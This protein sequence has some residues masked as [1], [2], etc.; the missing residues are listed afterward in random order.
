[1]ANI[2]SLNP[3]ELKSWLEKGEALLVDVRE[4][5]EHRSQF[6]DQALNLPLSEMSLDHPSF[7]QAKN[8]KLVFHCKTGQRS[9]LACEKLL[10][11]D[12]KLEIW[13]LTGGIDAWLKNK[14][15]TKSSGKQIM[16][17][18]RQVQLTISLMNL[19]GLG[20]Y[21]FDF[22]YGLILPLIAGL[23]LANAGLTGNCGMA[24]LLAKMPWNR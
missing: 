2:H 9:K 15:E 17:I 12:P 14:L 1:M 8:K 22:K 18:N 13:N 24:L 6:I 21:Y 4:P 23:G 16:S 19:V 5:A 11:S 7:P 3:T 20:L 10:K